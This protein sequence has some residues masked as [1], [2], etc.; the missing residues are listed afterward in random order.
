MSN[1][2]PPVSITINNY[3]T[4]E[5]G[6]T[7]QIPNDQ[8]QS[9]VRNEFIDQIVK[10]FNALIDKARADG[11]IPKFMADEAKQNVNETGEGMKEQTSAEAVDAV[12]EKYGAEVAEIFSSMEGDTM[13]MMEDMLLDTQSANTKGSKS[14]TEKEAEEAGASEGEGGGESVDG[15]GGGEETTAG[16]DGSAKDR[17]KNSGENWFVRMAMTLGLI[18]NRQAET[19]EK[20]ADK[21]TTQIAEQGDANAGLTEAKGKDDGNDT[22]GIAAAE[23]NVSDK[24]GE[25]FETMQKLQAEAQVMNSLA[26]IAQNVVSTLG[27]SLGTVTRKQ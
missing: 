20:L 6:S 11:E 10:L 7:N 5:V 16:A 17:I 8:A 2:I 21:V 15:E 9:A 24:D 3:N 18:M 19:I 4:E 14:N 12:R 27:Q 22:A 23:K 1:E 26:N 13:Q 25:K